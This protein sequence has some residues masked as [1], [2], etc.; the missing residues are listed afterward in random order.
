MSFKTA[1]S[2]SCRTEAFSKV[3]RRASRL[4]N[5]SLASSVKLPNALSSSPT[6]SNFCS[7]AS[8]VSSI[9]LCRSRMSWRTWP[10]S[11]SFSSSLP[12][13]MVADRSSVMNSTTML[14]I[15]SIFFSI[16]RRSR[17]DSK[18]PTISRTVTL[19]TSRTTAS[20]K[21]MDWRDGCS[22]KAR[23]VSASS[24][25][26]GDK[27]ATEAKSGATQR[28]FSCTL[29]LAFDELLLCAV[30]GRDEGSLSC[31][32]EVLWPPDTED[33]S[34]GFPG[35]PLGAVG[36]CCSSCCGSAVRPSSFRRT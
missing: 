31:C 36:C 32:R 7:Q 34:R 14:R 29:R 1:S 8:S 22:A 6:L 2:A 28:D 19:T 5:R 27:V 9:C 26:W 16:R 18:M 20:L 17:S 25:L 3:R 4:A 15:V 35:L 12:A 33:L 13:S 21:P 11:F 10:I 23:S 30:A 24:R